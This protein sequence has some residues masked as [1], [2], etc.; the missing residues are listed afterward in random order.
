MTLNPVKEFVRQ[1]MIE[2][3]YNLKDMVYLIHD[4]TGEFKL[5]FD[6]YG[7]IKSRSTLFG[8][9]YDLSGGS[10]TDGL[11]PPHGLEK[12]VSFNE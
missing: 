5:K 4:R 6:D 10:L 7:K 12:W 3:A 1:Q 9:N 8:L 2:F 11:N